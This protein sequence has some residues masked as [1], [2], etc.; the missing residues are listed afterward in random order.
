MWVAPLL[1]VVGLASLALSHPAELAWSGPMLVVWLLAPLVGWW[2]SR[3]IVPP[4]LKLSDVQWTFLRALARRTWRFFEVLVNAEENWLPPDNF[5]EVPEPTVA[6]RTSPTNI[7]LAL[8]ATLAACDFGYISVGRLL[9]RTA[10]TIGAMEKLGRYR[11]HFYNWYD[12]RTLQPL[13]PFYVSSVDSGNLLGALFTLRAGLLELKRR[14]LVC[15]RTVTGL[16]DT[17]HELQEQARGNPALLLK[18]RRA[19]AILESPPDDNPR[20]IIERLHQ[21]CQE[22]AD[23]TQAVPAHAPEELRWWAQAFERQCRDALDDLEGLIPEPQRL[24]PAPTLQE[25]ATSVPHGQRAADR[26]KQIDDLAQRCAELAVMDFSFLYDPASKLL[27][28]GYDAG[29]RRL[30]LS[31]YDRLASEARLASYILIA[32]GQLP[33]EHWFALGRQVTAHGGARAL[34]SW[35]GSMFEYL[36]PLLVMPTFEHTLLDETCQ[37]VVARQ[38]EYGRERGVPWG[39]SESCYNATDAGGAYQYRAFGVPGLG[40]KRGL[41]D[42]LVVAPYASALSLMVAPQVA[43]ENLQRLVAA[44]Y[45]GTFGLYEAIDFTPTRVPPGQT[46]RADPQL[47]GAPPGDEP[48][49]PGIPAAGAADAAPLSVGTAVQGDRAA[50]AGA[51]AQRRLAGAASCGRSRRCAQAAGKW[52]GGDA[53]LHVAAHADSRGAPAVQRPLPRHGH[54]CR[55]RVQPVE[56]PGRHTL[57]GGRDVRWVGP[58]LLPARRRRGA[59]WSTAFQPTRQASKHYEAIFVAGPRRVPPP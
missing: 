37:A 23:L 16:A 15:D 5:Q 13:R 43:C 34:L 14:S 49:G 31:R 55:R 40:Y 29:D 48:A 53:H 54:Q 36:M 35:S 39:I 2:I 10:N 46:R 21:A 44:G 45:H 52:R 3:P 32:Q 18:T 25:L 9:E 33:Q 30:D 27:S 50:A 24:G 8:L 38:I 47:H 26:L 7:G 1:G 11:G 4:A 41:A 12:T 58:V 51:R 59:L 20:A 28:I 57:A 17:L 19:R 6:S 56:R 22:A 42:D